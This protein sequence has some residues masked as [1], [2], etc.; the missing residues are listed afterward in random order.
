MYFKVKAKNFTE[1]VYSEL[2]NVGRSVLK[3]K[4]ILWKS[5]LIIAKD[6]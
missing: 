5:C 4:E 2:L 1:L 6:A 3:L